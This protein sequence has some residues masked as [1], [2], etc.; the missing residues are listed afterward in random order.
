MKPNRIFANKPLELRLV[1]P[2][3]VVIESRPIILPPCVFVAIRA[4]SARLRG[5][6]K[7]FIGVLRLNGAGAVPKCHRRAKSIGQY[8]T[9]ADTIRSGE[10]FIDAQAREQVGRHRRAVRL[11]DRIQSVVDKIRGGAVDGF[12]GATAKGVVRER[13]REARFADV[14]ELVS[15][16]PGIGSR[17]SAIGGRREIPVQIIRL[18]AGAECELLVVG[19]IVCR[20]KGWW[21]ITSSKNATSFDAIPGSVICVCEIAQRG[22][23]LFVR[24][25]RELGCHVVGIGDAVG[26]WIG[27]ARSAVGIIVPDRDGTGAL[28]NRCQSIG[29]VIKCT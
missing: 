19:V 11:L 15:C 10:K 1:I 6:A 4:R 14:C 7:G 26:V 8:C 25:A 9:D 28:R 27:H 5:D 2:R 21:K 12:T 20:G 13:C 16:V 3:T 17:D 23:P 29:I 22:P 24:D 18:G